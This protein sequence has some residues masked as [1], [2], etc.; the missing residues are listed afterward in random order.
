MSTA[1]STVLFEL[2]YCPPAAFFAELL[3]A[4]SLLLERHENYRKQT[5]RNR[6]LIL[7]AQGVQP[8][9][10]PV[11]DGNRSEKAP[12]DQLEIDYRQNWV[13]RHWRTLQTAYGNSSYFEFY[14]D[15]LHDIYVRKPD[16]L[17]D[18]N[19]AVLHLLLRCLRLTLPVA[20][21]A[22]WHASYPAQVLTDRRDW[23]TPKALPDTASGAGLRQEYRQCFGAGFVPGLSVL[24]LLFA[25]GPAA[26]TYLVPATSAGGEPGSEPLTQTAGLITDIR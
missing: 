8:L 15:Y 19:L 25:V 23:L 1:V 17:F 7:T 14:A 21:T 12:I 22:E 18:L 11:I 4:E 2:S 10:V 26:G 24:D 13:H 5:Y 16:R 9:T 3:S 6:C 20:F